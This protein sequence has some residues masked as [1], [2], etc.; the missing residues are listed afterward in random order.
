MHSQELA[1]VT[2]QAAIAK[3]YITMRQYSDATISG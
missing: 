1:A 2:D 3:A